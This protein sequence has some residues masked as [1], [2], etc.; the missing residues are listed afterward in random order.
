MQGARAHLRSKARDLLADAYA[1]AESARKAAAHYKR[2]LEYRLRFGGDSDE[3]KPQCIICMDHDPPPAQSGC[4]C[5]G[6]A[7]L[8]HVGCLVA[9]AVAQ[10]PHRGNAAWW[11][12]QTCKQHF[13]GPMRTGLA[14]AWW[15]RVRDEAE[16]SK[17]RLAA[18]DSLAQVRLADGQYAESEKIHREVLGVARRVLGEE[19]PNTL[20]SAGNLASSLL[21]QGKCAESEQINREVLGV[22]KRVLGEEHRVTL[23]VGNNLAQSLSEQ[24][25]CAES[26]QINREVLVVVRR[27]LGEE[28][29]YTLASAANLAMLLSTKQGG[30]VEAQRIM[31]EVYGVERRVLGEEHPSMLT[32]A[33]NLAILLAR[34]GHLAEAEEVLR[35]ALVVHHRVLGSS[36][37]HTLLTAKNWD[38]VRSQLTK[39]LDSYA[40]ADPAE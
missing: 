5:R 33:N 37:A 4:A 39:P 21:R 31:R 10:Q 3:R 28:H 27:V 40:A 34:Q 2:A 14:E 29:P 7:G 38:R 16:E 19:H 11:E 24:G 32:N 17:Q 9:S 30:H 12:C 26:E 13:T 20:A 15:S 22:S 36:H 1:M 25:K 8:A 23:M 6:E 35:A 18:A